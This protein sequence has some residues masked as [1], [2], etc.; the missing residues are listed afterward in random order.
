MC[1]FDLEKLQSIGF[2]ISEPI[3]IPFKFWQKQETTATDF[4]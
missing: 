4:P 2:A 1:L 3:S